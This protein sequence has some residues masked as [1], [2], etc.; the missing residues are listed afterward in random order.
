MRLVRTKILVAAFVVALSGAGVATAYGLKT[1][2]LKP[3]HCTKVG[4]TQVCAAKARTVTHSVTR[5]FV[6]TATS[7]VTVTSPPPPPAVSFGD[8]DFR[9][10]VDIQPGT[11]QASGGSDCYWARLSGFSGSLDDIIENGIG[12]PHP[13]VTIEP[14]DVG[15]QSDMCVG[16]AKIG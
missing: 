13:I 4:K 14:S 2:I 12:V 11:Y 6:S 1:I 15:F 3:G 8:G 10:G 5:T 7:T 16:W 9:V